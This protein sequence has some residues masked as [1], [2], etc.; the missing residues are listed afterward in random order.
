MDDIIDL[1]KKLVSIPS[2]LGDTEEIENFVA[3]E[4]GKVKGSNVDMVPVKGIGNCVLARVHHSDELPTVMLNGHLDTVEVCRSWTRDPFTPTV[5]GDGLYGLGSADMKAGVAISMKMFS[6]L[7][8]LKKVNVVFAGSVDEEGDSAGAFALLEKGIKADICL[9]PEPSGGTLMMGC[10][11]RVVFEVDVRGA[12]A[13]GSRPE[14]GV[15]A[16]SEAAKF[17]GA[18]DSIP[19]AEHEKLGRGSFCVLEMAG[20]TRTLSV[21]DSCRLKIDRHYVIGEEK[22][23]MLKM[24][25]K[26]ASEL[27]GNGHFEIGFLKS[28]PTPF[29]EPYLT[30]NTGL[31]K[32][33]TES[34]GGCFTFGKSVGDYNAFSKVMPTVVYGPAGVNWHAGDEYVSLS[35]V[36]T[37]MDGYLRFVQRL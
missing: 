9:I 25:K 1:V 20:G 27:R 6:E 17:V 5:E 35:S 21:P 32:T 29:L 2:I 37:C 3:G 4:L 23:Q 30:E 16:I 15:N 26:A 31:V 13:H 19:L 22:E 28:R 24:L 14:E 33:F 18:L 8:K 34:V 12:S 7:A 11:G 36:R 10:R